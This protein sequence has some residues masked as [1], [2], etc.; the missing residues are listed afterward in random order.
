LLLGHPAAWAAEP[1]PIFRDP[2]FE[3]L[4]NTTIV[5]VSKQE[6]QYFS[7]AASVHVISGEDIRRTGVRT[8]PEALRFAPGM[9]VAAINSRSYA[10]TMRGFNGTSA[11]KLLPLIDGRSLYS[12]R[13]AGTIWD[14]RDLPLDDV[15]Q[16]EVIGGPGGTTWG[17]NAVNGV[18]NIVTKDA[19]DTTGD[20]WVAGAGTFERGFLYARHGF[21]AGADGHA[22]VYV[23]AYQ[24]G[25]S[26]PVNV[27][28]NNDAWGQVRAGFR[29]DRAP[30]AGGHTTITGDVFYSDADQL[31]SRLPD[32]AHSSGGHLLAR[33]RAALSDKQEL[34]LQGYVDVLRRDSGGNKTEADVIDLDALVAPTGRESSGLSWGATARLSRLEDSVNSSGFTSAFDPAR[35]WLK[36]GSVFAEAT[37]RPAAGR[38]QLT[39]GVKAEYN[40]FTQWEFMPSVRAAWL[41]GPNFTAWAAWSQASRIPSRFENDQ[42]LTTNAGGLRL[43]TLPSPD[44][45]AEILDAYEIG[46]R[47]R[48]SNT[49]SADV[50]FFYHDYQRLVTSEGTTTTVPAGLDSRL[51]NLGHGNSHGAEVQLVWR[52][53]PWW[54]LKAAYTHLEMDLALD[55]RS[56]D[57]TLGLIAPVSPRNQLSLISSWNVGTRWEVDAWFRAVGRLPQPGRLIPAYQ[58]LDLRVGRQL[59]S[60]WEVSVVGQNL[61][62]PRHKEFRFFTVQAEVARGGYLRIERQF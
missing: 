19:A 55:P 49:V 60:G 46:W 28:D 20:R 18:I 30:A 34:R 3:E 56:N 51:A 36:Q 8:L 31:V 32:V 44:L 24:R 54:Q 26:E 58:T 35:R 17:A 10:V 27:A 9:E 29:Y 11:N 16:I 4:A 12:Q 25:D 38:V 47:W 1:S 33:H 7:A 43:R 23:Q 37:R 50:T 48:S 62:E 57:T 22:R 14:I 42:L 40:D 41:P 15:Q 59:G 6:E 2:T 5:S 45:W 39:A 53:F 21:A 52:P 13:F 61:L